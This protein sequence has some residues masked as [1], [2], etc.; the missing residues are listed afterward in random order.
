MLPL[1]IDD[2]LGSD[3]SRFDQKRRLLEQIVDVTRVIESLQASLNAVLVLGAAS[4]DP[5]E[6]AL[7]YCSALS[8]NLRNLPVR[9]IE[10]YYDNLEILIR[11]QLN[12]ILAYAD[13]DFSVDDEIEF[14]TLSSTPDAIDPLEL[15]EAFKRTAQTAV[16]LRVLLRKRGVAA[17]GSTIPISEQSIQQKLAHLEAQEKAQRT[18]IKAGIEEM[19]EELGWMIDN[20]AYPAGM[21]ATLRD[22]AGNLQRNMV[23]L[24]SGVPVERLS[25]ATETE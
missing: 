13:L 2:E 25:F 22:M 4:K 8:A 6:D 5:P 23:K 14:F 1:P 18:R 11:K 21:K 16:S 19:Q 12:R 7:D 15:L 17:P 9:Q 10:R 3:V 20:P 24:A